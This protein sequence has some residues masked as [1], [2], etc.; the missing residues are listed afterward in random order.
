MNR[1]SIARPFLSATAAIIVALIVS[2]LHAQLIEIP[3]HPPGPN[4]WIV[5]LTGQVPKDVVTEINL[6]CTELFEAN[7]RELVVVVIDTTEGR[8][9]RSY[10]TQ[11][12]NQWGIGSAFKNNGVLILAAL[13]DRRA[14]IIIGKGED[15]D[16]QVR[17]AEKI[18]DSII[19]PAFKA[20]DIGTALYEGARAS[21][22]RILGVAH[23][24]AP[25]DLERAAEKRGLPRPKPRWNFRREIARLGPWPWLIGFGFLGIGGL[26]WFRHFNRYR[27][28]NCLVCGSD[29]VMLSEEQDDEFLDPPEQLE[30]HLGSVDYDVW[31]CLHCEEVVKIRYGKWFTRYSECPQ[32]RYKTRSKI[33]RT[34]VAATTTHGGRVR[35]EEDCRNC[36]YHT[37]YSYTTP[38]ISTSSGSSGRSSGSSFGSGSSSGGFRGFG[39][40]GRFG[41]GSSSGRGASGGW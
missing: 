25:A 27:S 11:L 8:E 18:M 19:V 22:T 29:T 1:L 35:V 20:G 36:P 23:L 32:C 28:R 34:M 6:L 10:G 4:K 3:I 41:G 15:Y 12:F 9:H 14:E 7:N 2:S 30:E 24:E 39:G 33:T 26:V 17:I 40:G 16:H 31:A 13:E 5:D 21:A 37:S 38:R